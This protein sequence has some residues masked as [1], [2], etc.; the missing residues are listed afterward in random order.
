MVGGESTLQNNLKYQTEE[1]E[2]YKKLPSEHHNNNHCRQN[3]QNIWIV[4]NNMT[5]NIY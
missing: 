3:P 4:S 2:E 5:P 1:N